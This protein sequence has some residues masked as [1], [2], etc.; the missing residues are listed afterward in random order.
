MHINVL[1]TLMCTFISERNRC[2]CRKGESCAGHVSENVR[3]SGRKKTNSLQT[4]WKT[5]A[6]TSLGTRHVRS[7]FA[8]VWKKHTNQKNKGQGIPDWAWDGSTILIG[9]IVEFADQTEYPKMFDKPEFI[10][11]DKTLGF[12]LWALCIIVPNFIEIQKPQI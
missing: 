2:E 8:M 12:I 5:L 3:H 11:M 10:Y 1:Y 6:P 4:G 7:R 9:S